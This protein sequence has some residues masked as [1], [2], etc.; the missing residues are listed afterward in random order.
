M[1]ERTLDQA[2]KDIGILIAQI[3]WL[4]DAFGE[5]LDAEDAAL[6]AQ[7]RADWIDAHTA[8]QPFATPDAE[9]QWIADMDNACP[10]CGGSGHKDDVA[11][12]AP[13]AVE[14]ALRAADEFLSKCDYQPGRDFAGIMVKKGI[15]ALAKGSHP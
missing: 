9:G 4:E 14:D 2:A 10:H 5:S 13:D 7:I 15:A 11:Q 1:T 12:P 3:H 8:E 6:V